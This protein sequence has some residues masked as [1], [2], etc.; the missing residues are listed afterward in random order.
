MID[1]ENIA[2]QIYPTE[3][4]QNKTIWRVRYYM[5]GGTLTA[6]TFASLREAT[7]F[8]VYKISAWDVHDCYRVD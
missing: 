5:T 4:R 3:G 6:K 8:M 7:H 1:T 2:I